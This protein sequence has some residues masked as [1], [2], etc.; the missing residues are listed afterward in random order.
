MPIII[1]RYTGWLLA[2]APR[3]IARIPIKMANIEEKAD[4]LR[5]PEINVLIPHTIII[6]PT[7]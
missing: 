2:N 5:Y 4:T 7:I 3:A 6:I 1:A